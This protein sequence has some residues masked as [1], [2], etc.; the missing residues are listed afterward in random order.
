MKVLILAGGSGERLWP[1]SRK[2]YPKQFLKLHGDT[3]LLQQTTERV[4]GVVSPKDVVVLTGSDYKFLVLSDLKALR[5]PGNK[6]PGFHIIMEPVSRNTAPAIALGVKY[7]IEKLQCNEDEVVFLSPSDHII[8][9]IDGFAGYV[10]LAEEIARK[11]FLVT[12]G[13]RPDRPEAG[14]GY[15]K[16]GTRYQTAGSRNYYQV[17]KFTEKPDV[18]TAKRYISEGG[19]YW[20]SGMFAFRLGTIME[21]MRKYTPEIMKIMD[22][23]YEEMTSQFGKMPA[24]SLDYAVMERS[25]KAAVLPFDLFWND[26]GS[27]DALY[28]V[29]GKDKDRNVK[30]GDV[31]TVD[32]QDTMIIGNKR[33]IAAIGLKDCIVVDTDDALLIAK[34]GKAQKVKDIV[35]NLK[36]DARPEAEEH[37]TTHRPWG[38]YIV[39][40]TG[41]RYK[42]KRILVN[43]GEKLSMQMHHHR[44]EHWVMV[45]GSA[46]VT[47]GSKETFIHENESVYVP[48]STMHRLENPGKVP[49]EIIEV[50]NGEYTGEDDIVRYDDIYGRTKMQGEE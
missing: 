32:T 14:Y 46:K 17:E 22:L 24:I 49:L 47:I 50:Q 29:L 48:K 12:F 23:S 35:S 2:N 25:D 5:H 4:L 40:E 9:P 11:G 21:E 6:E 42:I 41:P 15:I 31:F 1:L 13:V 16:S 20:N 26:I 19:Y 30:M 10:R 45:K 18:E 8:M 39:L 43:P 36:K 37:V 38:S 28:D 33:H 3:S 34:K 27:W 7:C 44:S